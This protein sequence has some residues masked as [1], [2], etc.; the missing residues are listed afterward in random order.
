MSCLT[1][2]E[3]KL[4]LQPINA[5]VFKDDFSL[6]TSKEIQEYSQKYKVVKKKDRSNEEVKDLTIVQNT[7]VNKNIKD[8]LDK[9]TY[10]TSVLDRIVKNSHISY[11]KGCAL[12]LRILE[13]LKTTDSQELYNSFKKILNKL[14]NGQCDKEFIAEL[15]ERLTSIL[16]EY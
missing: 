5:D 4:G 3:F 13:V 8:I 16:E 10:Q 6:N 7:K 2:L 15:D 9:D 1:D 11:T 12:Y 14:I